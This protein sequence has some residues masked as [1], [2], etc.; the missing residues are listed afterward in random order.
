M[1][2]EKSISLMS[3]L[4]IV[5]NLTLLVLKL[6][7][8]FFTGNQ[9]MIADGLNSA[10]DVL[11]SLLSFIGNK[12]S[13]TP[14]DEDHP[15]GH[16][17]AEYIF[18]MMIGF[19][20]IFVAFTIFRSGLNSLITGSTFAYSIYLLLV[21]ALTVIVK[22][23]LYIYCNKLHKRYHSLLA[24]AAGV[25]HRNDVFISS[26]T[27]ASA[28]GGYFGIFIIDSIGSMLIAIWLCYS[29]FKIIMGAY[30]VLMDTNID[31]ETMRHFAK[32]IE[33]IEGLDHIDEITA[34]PTGLNFILIVKVSVDAYMSVYDSHKIAKEIKL[35]LLKENS[36]D[37]VIVH[38]NP[39]QFH[40]YKL[41]Y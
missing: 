10:G 38:I 11:S 36:V 6:I 24:Y 33:S 15:Y 25:D 35:I 22:L 3:I 21:I 8:G 13:C 9:T 32:L 29:S 27:L 41:D 37:D 39:A 19:I 17:K 40:E 30:A 12:I 7:V 34:Q 31:K 5:L 14:K 20:L 26:L 4:G 28:L 1:N 18:S 16:G 2:K 23:G